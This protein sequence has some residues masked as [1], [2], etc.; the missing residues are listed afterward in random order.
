MELKY[1]I[2]RRLLIL[3]PTVLGLLLLT[4]ILLRAI[5]VSDL[6][7]NYVNQHASLQQRAI[8]K[9]QAIALL[10]IG[11]PL[12]EQFFIYIVDII[13]GNLGNMYSNFYSGSVLV[14]ACTCTSIIPWKKHRTSW[15]LW[16]SHSWSGLSI[17]STG[18][19]YSQWCFTAYAHVT[20]GLYLER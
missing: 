4:F 3:I 18:W 13:H 5:P 20:C 14:M 11:K 17:N 2:I 15:C 7:A 6:I 1:Y 9:Q 16:P 12:P 19:I 8:E 10:G